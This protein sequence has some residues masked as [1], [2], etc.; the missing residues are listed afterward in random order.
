MRK[1][2][3][4]FFFEQLLRS[5]ADLLFPRSC[6]HCKTSVESTPLQYLCID[7]DRE[8]FRADP[9]AC[10][11]C[12]YPFWGVLAGPQTCP[13]CAELN[14]IFD[15][16]KTLF[17]AKGPGRSLIHEIKYHQGFYLMEDLARLI[18]ASPHYLEFFAGATLVPV[19]LHPTKERERG[20]NQSEII[21]QAL[22][23]AA[24]PPTRVEPLLERVRFTQT[25]TR[26]N[27][28]ER[29]QNVKN[30]FAITSNAVLLEDHSYILVDDVFT[31]G[32]TLNACA[33]TLR[34]AGASKISV[35]TLGHG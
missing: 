21:A 35:L 23:K 6:V 10:Q 17:L 5:M 8:L 27:R 4:R 7:C 25:Q 26:L 1:A 22:A 19:P 28:S 9:P 18:R 29:D 13:H 30:A 16:G 24:G 32:S 3:S 15:Q 12:G 31:T 11:T 14:P 33:A 2:H 34:D 20:F